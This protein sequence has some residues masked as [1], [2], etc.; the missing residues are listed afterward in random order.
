MRMAIRFEQPV[1]MASRCLDAN[2][3]L[4]SLVS[5]GFEDEE[6]E[7]RSEWRLSVL[8]EA[9]SREPEGSRMVMFE[10]GREGGGGID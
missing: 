9:E 8:E 2:A 4:F 10:C 6:V 7:C 3:C 1:H 5:L